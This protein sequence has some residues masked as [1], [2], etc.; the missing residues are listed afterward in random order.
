MRG[1]SRPSSRLSP[2]DS[3]QARVLGFPQER[4]QERVTVKLKK[5]YQGGDT[6]HRQRV[7]HLGRQEGPQGLGLSV[8]IGV[9]N[10]TGNEWEEYS[11]YSREGVGISRN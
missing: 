9:G 3:C 4:I 2:W 10:F 7:G 8:S 11:S 5:G 1:Q 6:R